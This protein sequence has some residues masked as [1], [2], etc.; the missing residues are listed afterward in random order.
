MLNHLL[1]FLLAPLSVFTLPAS[2][3]PGQLVI[4]VTSTSADQ[5]VLQFPESPTIKDPASATA[6]S[7]SCMVRQLYQF[8]DSDA[9]RL[10]NL[11]VRPNG[12]LVLDVVT[13][14]IIYE[15]DPSVSCPKPKMLHTFAGV[16][17][18]L[19][20]DEIAPDVFAVVVGNFTNPEVHQPGSFS[21][22]SVNLTSSKGPIVTLIT[23]LPDSNALN[24]LATLPGTPPMVMIADSQLGALWRVNTATG[25]HT[26][27]YD[28]PLL[29]NTTS[30]NLGVN[31]I[32]IFQKKLYF[33]NSAQASYGRI[34]LHDDGSAAG[35]VEILARI[36]LKGIWDDFDMDWEG[37][38]WVATHRGDLMEVAVDGRQRNTTI[39][40][41]G[42]NGL[43]MLDPTSARFGKGSKKE[44]KTLYVSTAGNND[45]S[46]QV[47]AIDVCQM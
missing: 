39:N 46:A 32:R 28:S 7:P 27:I 9:T 8:H 30:K 6:P 26:K 14:P 2:S 36:E 18:V 16:T 29:A 45:G 42:C 11:A 4:E 34:S 1:L 24:G 38:A 37:N 40:T 17:S 5:L 12:K 25:D 23:A 22:Y 13:K 33:F 21:L 15:L 3:V 44:E 35:E 41:K 43:Q 19:G 31:G 20:I 10:E 47:L